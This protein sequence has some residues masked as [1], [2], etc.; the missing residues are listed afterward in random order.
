MAMGMR[1]LSTGTVV[2][3]RYKILQVLGSGG[4]GVT[5]KV[6]D[7]KENSIAVLKEYMPLDIAH[8][9]PGSAEIRPISDGTREQYRKFYE[10]FYKEAQTIYM[11]RG[12]PNIVE[13]NNLF[14]DNNTVYYVMEYVE[15]MDMKQLLKKNGGKLSWEVLMPLMKQVVAGLS[16]VHASGLIHCDISPD[17]IFL[18]K[19][20]RIKLLDFGAAKSTLRG[21]VET[22]VIV[23]KAGF[24]PYEQ[25]RGKN[26]DAW[27]DVYALAATIYLCITGKMV[28]DSR[29]RIVNDK[30]IWPS[31]M[32]IAIPSNSWEQALKKGM[33]VRVE[34]RYQS[35]T[36]FWAALNAGNAQ[37]RTSGQSRAVP[38]LRCIQG[39]FANR[40]IQVSRMLCL[41]VNPNV[42][43][44]PFPM[45]TP[46]ISRQH[47]KLWPDNGDILVMDLG[48]TYGTFIDGNRL[49]PGL[50][51]KL[52]SGSTLIMGGGQIFRRP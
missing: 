20:G 21:S 2:H 6:Q 25:M 27:T 34:D 31:Q 13:I 24:T 44:I 14:Y 42:C 11:L 5:Y 29:E 30:T 26:M 16:Q 50:V 37:Q 43:H 18:M 15:G 32:G 33:A 19:G 39:V 9:V 38:E 7:L 17:N 45:G 28:P 48:S 22:S 51:Y 40:S 41:G 47:L 52:A 49:T 23:A 36:E 8:R 46:G 1:E 35:V 10:Q 3:R 12:H 4:F